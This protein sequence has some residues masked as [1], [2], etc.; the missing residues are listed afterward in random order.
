MSDSTPA[1]ESFNIE[2]PAFALGACF[3]Q[4]HFSDVYVPILQ[5]FV[6]LQR[7][8]L[9]HR[10][11]SCRFAVQTLLN[12][13]SNEP[14]CAAVRIRVW[15]SWRARRRHAMH[16]LLRV[17]VLPSPAGSGGRLLCR[18]ARGH[19]NRFPGFCFSAIQN[20]RI[21]F[22]KDLFQIRF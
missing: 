17:R 10:A 6:V 9:P 4:R 20:L 5:D 22:L 14:L 18:A 13:H 2:Q 11:S 15:L 19:P 12:N 21:R 7:A 16:N 8:S 1:F 3:K